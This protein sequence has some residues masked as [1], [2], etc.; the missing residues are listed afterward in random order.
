MGRPK[1]PMRWAQGRYRDTRARHIRAGAKW[2]LTFEEW[3]NWWLSYG[4]DKNSRNLG[5]TTTDSLCISR[6]DKNLPFRLDN[7]TPATRGASKT[8]PNLPSI[9]LNQPKLKLRK[10]KDE[11]Y[12]MYEPWLRM[13]A[14]ANF[15]GEQFDLTF[16][17]FAE[18]WGD[19]WSKRGRA[20]DALAMTR[21][22]PEGPW[23][24]KNTVIVTRREQLQRAQ[25][26]RRLKRS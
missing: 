24:Y 5:R 4:V 12:P 7:L 2:E 18:I 21:E 11:R 26:L 23:D 10:I 17:Q 22:D 3:Y 15:R 20:S 6:K 25:E 14:Q 16:D 9:N 19:K 1:Q 13:R 8:H